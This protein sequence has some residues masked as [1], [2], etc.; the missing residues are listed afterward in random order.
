MERRT[1]L[2]LSLVA[3]GATFLKSMAQ[4]AGIGR[5]RPWTGFGAGRPAHHA[6]LSRQ[7]SSGWF[8]RRQGGRDPASRIRRRAN[9]RVNS[10]GDA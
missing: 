2:K 10:C 8:A 9:P 3:A 4:R 6:V 1:L 5:R 7:R